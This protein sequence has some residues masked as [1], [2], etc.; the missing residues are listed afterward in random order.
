MASAE[1]S[2]WHA[3]PWRGR[4]AFVRRFRAL[5]L[6]H[7]DE[8]C[9]LMEDEVGKPRH[10]AL[11]ADIA[12]LLA[13][14]VHVEKHGARV[15]RDRRLA[16]TPLWMWGTRVV[17]RR[18][19]LGQVAIIATW[20][21][22]VQLLGIQLVHA[23][24]AGNTVVVKPSE[25]APRTQRLL[26]E[27]ACEAGLPP[28]VLTWTNATREA[29]AELL[30][31][32]RFDHVIFT[33]STAVGRGIALALAPTLTS[34]TL[35]LSGRD[36]ALVLADA[37]PV[38]AAR[39]IFA[40]FTMNH[41]QT[42]MAPRRALVDRLAH[43]PFVRE[44]KRLAK[45]API[46]PLIDE[47]AA[48]RCYELASAALALGA[49]DAAGA[50]PPPRGRLWRASVLLDC[51][52][53]AEAVAGTHFGPLLAVVRV[54]DEDHALAIHRACGQHL[55]TSVFTRGD[56]GALVG[57]LGAT[58]VTINDVI[59]PTAHPA[60]SIGGSGESGIGLSRGDEGLRGL[61]RP[62]FVSTSRF[63]A[64]EVVKP[65]TSRQL[66]WLWRGIRW[67]YRGETPPPRTLPGPAASSA[68]TPGAGAA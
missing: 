57:R 27:L 48:L 55:A 1:N 49:I 12:P 59:V 39:A 28:G 66:S 22:P 25:R 14:C 34:A 56:A 15:L 11:L 33:G 8:L 36:S 53:E 60:A 2:S 18:V 45:D 21:Y 67:M 6:A 44:M 37:D 10:E 17:E 51:P 24:A 7:A 26:L 42:C 4:A 62:V 40:G 41:G 50:T 23:L 68:A 35:E 63:G 43:E 58:S 32:R 16:G 30:A 54:R 3:E 52:E 38:R 29:G 47:G 64:A 13:A 31:S 19:P 65:P 5:V 46:R 20:N 61:T 9:A